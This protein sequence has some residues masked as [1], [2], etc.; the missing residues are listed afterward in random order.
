MHATTFTIP[1]PYYTDTEHHS[2]SESS[3]SS[4][5]DDLQQSAVGDNGS[6]IAFATPTSH[7]TPGNG[8]YHASRSPANGNQVQERGQPFK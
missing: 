6:G 4:V 7:A 8:Y 3:S 2:G 1:F 5:S